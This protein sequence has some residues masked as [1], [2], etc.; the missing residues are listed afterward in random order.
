[1]MN[2]DQIK[3]Q[4][5]NP[6]AVGLW[7]LGIVLMVLWADLIGLID[8]KSAPIIL[9]WI[10][11][12]GIAQTLC[13]IIELRNGSLLTGNMLTAFGLFFMFGLSICQTLS[14]YVPVWFLQKVGAAPSTLLGIVVCYLAVM[15][16]FFLPLLARGPSLL[17]WTILVAI[18]VIFGLGFA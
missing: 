2:N 1:M 11:V 8:S 9:G 17:F 16:I 18:P 4:W 10:F 5:A 15:L 7:A 6:G 12:A 14:L 3:S 13:G